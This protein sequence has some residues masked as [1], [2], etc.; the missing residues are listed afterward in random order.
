MH[1][2]NYFSIYDLFVPLHRDVGVVHNFKSVRPFDTLVICSIGTLA[3]A[4]A[5]FSKVI[6]VKT[7][8]TFLYLGCF[9]SC[10]YQERSWNSQG[11]IGAG[12]IVLILE[13]GIRGLP[14]VNACAVRRVQ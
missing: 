13:Q 4:L 7:N 5:N 11:E 8:P 3:Y 10:L 9:R 6:G 1:F 2:K 12:K 14:F